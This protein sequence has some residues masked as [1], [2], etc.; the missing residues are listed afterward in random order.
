MYR[1][2]E[3]GVQLFSIGAEQEVTRDSETDTMSG[4]YLSLGGPVPHIARLNTNSRNNQEE[5]STAHQQ[6]KALTRPTSLEEL[7]GVDFENM[8]R[9][10]GLLTDRR[11]VEPPCWMKDYLHR[12]NEGC[13]LYYKRVNGIPLGGGIIQRF[14]SVLSR[15]GLLLVQAVGAL[16]G[17]IGR[18]SRRTTSLMFWSICFGR[19]SRNGTPM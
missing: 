12:D 13:L 8:Q 15:A 2:S 18:I 5:T 4:L 3:V 19:V 11:N 7:P 16:D 10:K 9:R 14:F 17:M 1:L 6:W